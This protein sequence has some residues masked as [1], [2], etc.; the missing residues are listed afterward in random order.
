LAMVPRDLFW[1]NEQGDS[2]YYVNDNRQVAR[3]LPVDVQ[4]HP[5]IRI[6]LHPL[7]YKR[8]YLLGLM[9]LSIMWLREVQEDTSLLLRRD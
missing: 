2:W 9:N 7:A 1:C 6:G 4:K 3:S 5:L 8:A